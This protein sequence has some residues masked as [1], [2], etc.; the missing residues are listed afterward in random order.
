MV[1]CC[2]RSNLTELLRALISRS[3][4]DFSLEKLQAELSIRRA[5]DSAGT[6]AERADY[7]FAVLSFH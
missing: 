4:L 3:P 1:Q 2:F 5:E 6:R 7:W